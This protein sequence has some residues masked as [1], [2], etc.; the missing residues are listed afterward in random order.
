MFSIK[1]VANNLQISTQA[2]YK[3][4]PRLLSEG[5]AYKENNITYIT[6]EGYNELQS[7]RVANISTSKLQNVVQQIGR[8]LQSIDQPI[9]Q[10]KQSP[11]TV[12]VELYNIVQEQ[13]KDM[14]NQRDYFK[15]LYEQKDKAFNDIVNQRL[16]TGT[17]EGQN[18]IT[19][20]N[21]LFNKA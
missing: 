16:L 19:F 2:V 7:K 3:H 15:S 4:I 20:W 21:R 11:A 17:T 18:K 13:L 10:L 8:E 5:K 14:Q 6:A 1:E 12:S 9:E